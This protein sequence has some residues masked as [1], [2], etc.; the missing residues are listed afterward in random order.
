MYKA[1]PSVLSV[2][3]CA[4]DHQNIS[5][6]LVEQFEADVHAVAT[7]DLALQALRD[8]RFDLI[9]VNRL[10]DAD[11]VSGLDFIKRLQN[12]DETRGTAVML[13]SNY[14]EAQEAAI[15]LGARPGFG[16]GSLESQ[17]TRENLAAVLT[18]SVLADPK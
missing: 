8:G 18:R 5:R 2:G 7:A 12:H 4:F 11:G 6:L 15:A 9:L 10:F 13:L 14:P 1:A 16:K 3:N 17:Q